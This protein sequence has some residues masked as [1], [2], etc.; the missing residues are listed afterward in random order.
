MF[1]SKCGKEMAEEQKFCAACG[2]SVN[3]AP[4]QETVTMQM[5]SHRGPEKSGIVA[6]I[7]CFFF[8]GLGFHRFYMGQTGMGILYI[9]LSLVLFFMSAGVLNLFFWCVLIIESL[10]YIFGGKERF[11]QR[12]Y[13]KQVTQNVQI[14]K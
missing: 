11:N 5:I 4:K 12:I 6:G 8:G 3:G 2:T 1:C 10:V 14:I 13:G 7:L 9:M